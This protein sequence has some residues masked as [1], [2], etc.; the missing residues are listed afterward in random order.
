MAEAPKD[1]WQAHARQWSRIGGP[2]RPGDEDVALMARWL[3]ERPGHGLLLGVTPELTALSDSLLALDRDGAMIDR[4]WRPRTAQQKAQQGDWLDPAVDGVQF[5]FAVGD[6][7][8]NMLSYVGDYARLFARLRERLRDDGLLLLRVFCTPEQGETPEAVLAAA[9]QGGIG[10]FHAFK[11]RLAMAMVA[12]QRG[13]DSA[14]IGVHHIH[15]R[16]EEL[17]P[18]RAQLAAAAGWLTADIDTIDVYRDSATVYSFPTRSQFRA[19]LPDYVEEIGSAHGAY[20]LAERCPV[21]ALR[22]HR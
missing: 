16:F 4:L 6:G 22:L 15:Q 12:Q 5:D 19:A 8:L 21:I 14:N 7:S 18:D 11:W 13:P 10:S 20:E 9:R 2:L 17:A 3:G 1:H